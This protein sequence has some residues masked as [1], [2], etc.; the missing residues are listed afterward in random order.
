MAGAQVDI[1]VDF[2]AEVAVSSAEVPFVYGAYGKKSC[3]WG[4]ILHSGGFLRFFGGIFCLNT[5]S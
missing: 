1:I 4:T 3:K 5:G 2:K